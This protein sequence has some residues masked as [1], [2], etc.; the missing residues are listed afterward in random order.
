MRG[1]AF[2]LADNAWAS[3]PPAW[4]ES[5]EARASLR[6][7]HGHARGGT[8]RCDGLPHGGLSPLIPARKERT[9]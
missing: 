8:I 5:P 4:G 3:S 7:A 1:H 6:M 9:K 2:A